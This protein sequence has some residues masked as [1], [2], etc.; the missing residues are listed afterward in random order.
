MVR[1]AAGV[2]HAAAAAP[3]LAAVGSG[4]SGFTT[5]LSVTLSAATQ[6]GDVIVVLGTNYAG[7]AAAISG[8]TGCGATW[9]RLEGGALGKMD[10]WIGKT[11]TAGQT[12]VHIAYG[13]GGGQAAGYAS[14]WRGANSTA[15]AHISANSVSPGTPTT[16][17]MT[18]TAANQVAIGAWYDESV[19]GGT[20]AD[21][22]SA[23]T[24]DNPDVI[25]GNSSIYKPAHFVTTA[26]GQTL[27]HK[28]SAS[29]SASGWGIA[30]AAVLLNPA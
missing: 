17:T 6:T 13:G 3:T 4:T 21:L 7:N 19:S 9:T 23:W 29:I 11:P 25:G 10:L 30:G 18:S 16:G 26:A 24:V 27:T 28:R 22:P 1:A 15:A 12:V 14:L 20:A 8:V 2:S 5:S